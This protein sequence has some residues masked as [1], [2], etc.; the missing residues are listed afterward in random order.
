MT[1][2]CDSWAVALFLYAFFFFCL[3]MTELHF[4]RGLQYDSV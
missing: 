1:G 4:T 2:V 3:A